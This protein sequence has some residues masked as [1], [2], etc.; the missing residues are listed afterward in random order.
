MFERRALPSYQ[1]R[2]RGTITAP[3]SPR[4]SNPNAR[5]P[6]LVGVDP[7]A[8]RHAGQFGS[9]SN[10]SANARN[11]PPNLARRSSGGIA[12]NSSLQKRRLAA[13]YAVG[14]PAR[15][16]AIAV[17]R[18]AIRSSRRAGA[19]SVGQNAGESEDISCLMSQ[20]AHQSRMIAIRE[21][22]EKDAGREVGRGADHPTG[23][24]YLS[25]NLPRLPLIQ[26]VSFGIKSGTGWLQ[27]HVPTSARRQTWRVTEINCG[28][29]EM[30]SSSR[31]DLAARRWLVSLQ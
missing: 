28:V 22:G 16:S 24:A 31:C 29:L 8:T 20:K 9:L 19:R 15:D 23:F 1:K 10:R 25:I 13:D 7:R 27:L 12:V 2:D 5:P 6:I 4:R 21:R 26:I 17:M 14:E 18:D 30:L 3:P 11:R